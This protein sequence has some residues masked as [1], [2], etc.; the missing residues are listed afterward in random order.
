[1]H[2]GLTYDRRATY[3]AAGW[4][5]EQAGEFDQDETIDALES[6]L[7][8]RGHVVD[9]IGHIRQL[10]RRLADGQ[11]WDLVFNICEGAFGAGRE[12][13]VP[14]LLEA[15]GIAYTFSDPL[16]M[17]LCL[18]KAM[19]KAMVRQA[20][21]AA[22]DG[23][24]VRTL[25]EVPHP[26][27]R[28]FPLFVKPVAEGTG[29]GISTASIVHDRRGLLEQCRTLLEQFRQPVLVETYLAGREF[30][31]GLIGTGTASRVL[32]TLEI[33]L[34]AGAEPG[35]YSFYNK[36]YCER[37]VEYILVRPADPTV[38]AV[39]QLAL[40]AWQ[41]LGCRDAGRIDVRCDADGKPCFLE[42]NPLAG[43]HPTHSDLPMLCTA[44]GISYEQLIDWIVS[45]AAC[46]IPQAAVCR[47]KLERLDELPDDRQPVSANSSRQCDPNK[48]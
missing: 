13:Q 14:A 19:A 28:F 26:P 9:R 22:P 30:T 25:D 1:M 29:K 35:V 8:S 6:A 31:V 15:Y 2:I 39:E 36:E 24:L 37:L 33:R 43:L 48:L 38:A 23:W 27:N 21:L 7:Q 18:D 16:V 45:S 46:R 34:T 10:V 17:G 3:L 40:D 42:A 5:V 12:A 41:A 20:G 44:L 32:G 47:R 4:S 11:R